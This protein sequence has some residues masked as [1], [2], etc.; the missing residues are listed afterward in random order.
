MEDLI[1]RIRRKLEVYKLDAP[2]VPTSVEKFEAQ[3]MR[4][5]RQVDKLTYDVYQEFEH[6][7]PKGEKSIIKVINR[8]RDYLKKSSTS[9]FTS[10]QLRQIESFRKN[11]AQW[12]DTQK[13]KIYRPILTKDDIQIFNDYAKTV[14]NELIDYESRGWYHSTAQFTLLFLD[15]LEKI[16]KF[17]QNNPEMVEVIR[18][19]S[20]KMK[21]WLARMN[22]K[23]NQ[24][25]PLDYEDGYNL[26]EDFR[27]LILQY[28][29]DRKSFRIREE[30]KRIISYLEWLEMGANIITK[31]G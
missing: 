10:A 26:N 19:E 25:Q 14:E 28:K 21:D 12:T 30:N 16:A 17:H 31:D 18:K 2:I 27:N 13:N 24:T 11:E 23:Y 5:Y 6:K 7:D 20:L 22:T 9:D 29:V 4:F 15:Y 1:G 3:Y 8:V